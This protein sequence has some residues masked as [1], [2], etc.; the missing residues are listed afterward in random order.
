MALRG[1]RGAVEALVL[2]AAQAHVIADDVQH[3]HHLAED[4]HPAGVARW[5]QMSVM[6]QGEQS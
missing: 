4:Q 2:E 1:G 3:A 6:L 5:K